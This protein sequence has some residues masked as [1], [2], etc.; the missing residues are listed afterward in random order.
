MSFFLL[1]N[2]SF[3]N[4]QTKMGYMSFRADRGKNRRNGAA[5][6]AVLLPIR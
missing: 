2:S 5:P 4:G 1:E 6:A 3:T